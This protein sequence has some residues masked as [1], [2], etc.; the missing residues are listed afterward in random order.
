MTKKTI[1]IVLVLA[2]LGIAGYFAWANFHHRN[3]SSTP[4]ADGDIETYHCA[5]H[6]WVVSDKPGTC[7]IC[8]MALT[9]V[10]KDQGGKQEGVV[11]VDPAMIQNMGVKTEVVQRRDLASS[12]RAT[13]RVDYDETQRSVIT[14]KFSGFIER[15]YADQT[16]KD[17]RAGQPLFE[18][19]SPELVAAQQ[20]Y[21]QAIR[22]K[23]SL[24]SAD[25][26]TA[27]S[28]D[29]LVQGARRKLE[30]WDIS[31]AQIN[32]VERSGEA[33]RTLTIHS[34]FS[35]VV[36]EKNV[37]A[38]MM[39]EAG[40]PLLELADVSKLWIYADLYQSQLA[41]LKV[42]DPARIELPSMPGRSLS[43]KVTFI[44]PALQKESRTATL[45]IEVAD[46]GRMLKKDM[47]VMVEL[48]PSVTL[49]A[50]AI[51]ERSVIHSG[52]RDVIVLSLGNGKF[53]SV[54][55]ALGALSNGYYEVLRGVNEGDTIV[56]SSQFLIDS[57]SNLRSG[58]A[59]MQ[60]MDDMPI[61]RPE[62]STPQPVKETTR[63]VP[64]TTVPEPKERTS[65]E[66]VPAE[67]I[68]PVCGMTV[69]TT[70]ELKYAHNGTTYYFCAASELEDFKKD[71][72]KFL[73]KK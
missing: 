11:Q 9:L 48:A 3:S 59:G 2:S 20:E 5:M 52:S 22:Y 67:A 8:G 12:I 15:L 19:Y 39:V 73:V 26:A 50:I 60:N 54:N 23:S 63:T 56:T 47:Y 27:K 31:P 38:G 42:N 34:P 25:A 14:T 30:L 49:N 7:P 41:W 51:P 21:L 4:R 58:M 61:A 29:D 1:I 44:Y 28:A 40:M 13:G 65:E 66:K 72:E 57:E 36:V 6:P 46:E 37:V 71:P 69:P 64:V 45:R 55:V 18:I 32:E 16:G 10:H 33:R 43:G 35:G 70:T 62:S 53:R 24:A 68:D 17:V